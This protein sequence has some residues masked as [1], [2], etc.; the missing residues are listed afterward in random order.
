M[1][2][3]VICGLERSGTTLVSELFRQ[4]PNV[5]AG[6]E[7][8]VLL[9]PSPRDFPANQPFADNMLHDWGLTHDALRACCDTDDFITF[10]ARLQAASTALAP[11]T[12]T[13]FDKT[14][15]YL[16]TLDSCMARIN[17]PFIATFKD[18]RSTVYSDFKSS[19]AADFD[20]W[21]DA[22]APDK[23][24]YM[25]LHYQQLERARRAADPRLCIVRLE[26]LCLQPRATCTRI[27]A[28][29][30]YDFDFSYVAFRPGRYQLAPVGSISVGMPFA[31]INGLGRVRSDRVGAV[32]A[33]FAAW[34]CDA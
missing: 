31:Y 23:I 3:F 5:D 12:K 27:L 7:V 28:H 29:A 30:G 19:G 1:V 22:Y 13:I 9:Q 17:V 4:L 11:G 8:G 32:F 15:R 6:F 26:D 24:N 16:A 20:R 10:Y 18:P 25:R 34:F 33:E 21:F 2:G 14:P